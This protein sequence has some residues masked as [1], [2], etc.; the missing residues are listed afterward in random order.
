MTVTDNDLIFASIPAKRSLAALC[1]RGPVPASQFAEPYKVSY[2]IA[3]IRAP[4]VAE[5]STALEG[6]MN[7]IALH[8]VFGTLI[9]TLL[10]FSSQEA[11]AH[12][13]GIDSYGGHRDIKAGNYH[14]HQG[15]CAGRTFHSQADAIKAGYKR[16]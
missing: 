16:P 1:S 8:A 4:I 10:A 6:V 3:L 12:G 15:V 13:G 11:I 7:R 9:F 2:K 14:S 5:P